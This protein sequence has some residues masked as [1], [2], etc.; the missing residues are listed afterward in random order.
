LHDVGTHWNLSSRN[1]STKPSA[2]S[3][4]PWSQIRLY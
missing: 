3:P 1:I 4:S 2:E